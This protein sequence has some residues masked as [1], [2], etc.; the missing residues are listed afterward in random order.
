MEKN[1]FEE[2]RAGKPYHILDPDYVEQVHS[3]MKRCRHI[4]WKIAQTDPDEIGDLAEF[5]LSSR[6]RF[7][8]GTDILADGGCTASYWYGNLQ[9]L[10]ATH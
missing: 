6:G 5:L 9:Y 4:C 7:I 8:S 3:E 2:L 1:V 10:K